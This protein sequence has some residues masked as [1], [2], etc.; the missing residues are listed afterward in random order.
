M[1]N[2]Q[3]ENGHTRIAHEITEALVRS[4]L[5]G[6]QLRATL[7]II[8]LT[9]GFHRKEMTTNV[10]AFAT[11]LKTTKAYVKET[12]SQLESFH[13][14]TVEWATPDVCKIIFNKDLDKWKCFL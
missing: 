1:A 2:P 6:A 12:F 4:N 9:Y 7:W 5:S 13:V 8:R 14:I 10:N 11:K 3:L